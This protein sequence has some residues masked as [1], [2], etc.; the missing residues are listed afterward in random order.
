MQS[1]CSLSSAH[2]HLSAAPTGS[3]A[4]PPWLM[5][6]GPV[7]ALWLSSKESKAC[8]GAEGKRI[9]KNNHVR[10]EESIM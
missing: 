5:L 2:G 8:L 3:T 9:K 4:F 7:T 1:L 6:L 10:P